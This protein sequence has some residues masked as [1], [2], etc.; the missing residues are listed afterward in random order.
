M[1][2]D[3]GFQPGIFLRE[4]LTKYDNRLI[5][6]SYPD[7]WGHMGRYHRAYPTLLVGQQA[8]VATRLETL[9]KAKIHTGRATDIPLV[10]LGLKPTTYQTRIISIRGEWDI[11]SDLAAEQVANAAGYMG[12]RDVVGETLDAMD[13]ALTQRENELVIFGDSVE[14][15][16]G[17]LS[18]E[19][20]GVRVVNVAGGTN[21][22]TMSA[23]DL[24]NLIRNE[25]TA[26]MKRSLLTVNSIVILCTVDLYNSLT[27][28]FADS[29][30]SPLDRLTGKLGGG[31]VRQI[32]PLN[33]LS[34]EYLEKY[35]VHVA[36]TD[37]DRFVLME[38]FE[39]EPGVSVRAALEREFFT[40][41]RTPLRQSGDTTYS[42]TSFCG[43][44]EIKFNYPWKTTYVDYDKFV[45][46]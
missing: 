42:V 9:G 40:V 3:L 17:L 22:H 4:S 44:S 7:R 30:G 31:F 28:K 2:L 41:M 14:G 34:S 39:I 6:P 36:G 13:D 24:F 26:F 37:R 5:Y 12:K 46:A 19:N 15:M 45:A 38:N 27:Q 25:V 1:P 23:I 10:N 21:L 18:G 33:E 8:I 16:S 35:G 29:D 11:I 32:V 20:S 43:T